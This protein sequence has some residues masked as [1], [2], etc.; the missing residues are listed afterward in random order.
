LLLPTPIGMDTDVVTQVEKVL[1][2]ANLNV[3]FLSIAKLKALKQCLSNGIEF[4]DK[5]LMQNASG[6]CMHADRGDSNIDIVHG[7]SQRSPH[8]KNM[9]PEKTVDRNIANLW[10]SM[11]EDFLFDK[12][13]AVWRVG[14]PPSQSMISP[15]IRMSGCRLQ[16]IVTPTYGI[17][18]NSQDGRLCKGKWNIRVYSSSG[19]KMASVKF[20]ETT[21]K[22]KVG[23]D[24]FIRR[25]LHALIVCSL[26][27][28]IALEKSRDSWMAERKLDEIRS[29]SYLELV[30]PEEYNL[31]PCPKVDSQESE[32]EASN[33][34]RTSLKP[35]HNVSPS[36][37]IEDLG[38]WEDT[39][40]Q[41]PKGEVD[42]FAKS[43]LRKIT[44]SEGK[45]NTK[46]SSP[47]LLKSGNGK[48]FIS[49]KRRKYTIGEN[50]LT[51]IE[52]GD[53]AG[54]WI[55]AIIF[56]WSEEHNAWDVGILEHERIGYPSKVHV[57]DG[58]IL[59]TIQSIDNTSE[60]RGSIQNGGRWSERPLPHN[61][62]SE[63]IYNT[64]PMMEESDDD[65][66][67]SFRPSSEMGD[68][69]DQIVS[70][71]DSKKL[72]L[73][74][75]QSTGSGAIQIDGK[76][77][78]KRK[79]I[80]EEIVESERVYT[81]GLIKLHEEF[82]TPIFDKY[83]IPTSFEEGMVKNSKEIME[84]H[85]KKFLPAL[86]ICLKKGAGI[87]SIFSE[88]VEQ[89]EI[90]LSYVS[91]YDHVMNL[92][93]SMRDSREKFRNFLWE[94]EKS[95]DSF[96]SYLILPVQRVPRYRL[97]LESL[98]KATPSDSPEHNDVSSALESIKK[99]CQQ[100]NEH[101]REIERMTR[102]GQIQSQISG[103]PESLH[104][105][106]SARKR[107]Y[108]DDCLFKEVQKGLNFRSKYRRLYLFS[109]V[110]IITNRDRFYKAYHPLQSIRVTQTSDKKFSLQFRTRDAEKPDI[111]TFLRNDNRGLL[112]AFVKQLE[113]MKRQHVISF[114]PSDDSESDIDEQNLRA[115]E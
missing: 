113:Q 114:I 82:Y 62:E 65:E 85:S 35:N 110:L 27:K 53:Y 87:P 70:L 18:L 30:S 101:K 61:R 57:K 83:L 112:S 16:L 59:K 69:F 42:L 48:D 100:I 19:L 98:L 75:L 86:E 106:S 76:L 28:F 66:D 12:N 10:D 49:S 54:M 104:S 56:D 4:V 15:G 8:F 77:A 31:F 89:F 20:Q 79:N 3:E 78:R 108:L 93:E 22:D 73:F 29:Q 64:L 1:E 47:L 51:K 37:D 46:P 105:R 17:Y 6:H 45:I 39:P 41:S 111:K 97:L 91:D 115:R 88:F 40:F 72:F 34:V 52:R 11:L 63:S 26:K 24:N 67:N 81:K 21:F 7:I 90:Y 5:K 102:L 9:D 58:L 95:Q 32:E 60:G 33:D 96:Y 25:P 44:M 55:N 2:L 68:K 84:L 23:K 99:L 38:S 43:I 103:L 36:Q 50:V 14:L 71:N 80:L 74:D 107:E 109:D 94:R 13:K 92:V